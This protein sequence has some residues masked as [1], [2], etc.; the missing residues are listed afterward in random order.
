M[1]REIIPLYG[2]TGSPVD[3]EV[4][5]CDTIIDPKESYVYGFRFLLPDG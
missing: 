1:F 5:L 4:L 3:P 2:A